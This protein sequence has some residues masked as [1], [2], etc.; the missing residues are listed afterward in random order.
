MYKNCNQHRFFYWPLYIFL[1]LVFSAEIQASSEDTVLLTIADPFIE[2]RTGPG[3]AY[4][5]FHVLDRGQ[6]FSIIERKTLWYKIRSQNKKTGNK[7]GWVSKQ[8]MQQTLLPSGQYLQLSEETQEDFI[9]RQWE[10]G[11]TSGQLA[12]AP[13]LSVYGGYLLTENISAEITLAHS[14]ASVSSSNMVKL[15]LLMQPFPEWW[16]SPFFTLGAGSLQ[17]IPK[18]TLIDPADKQN[19]ISQVGLGIKTYLT[20]KFILRFE[21]NQYIIFSA[22]NDKDENEDIAEW[23]LGFA[24]FF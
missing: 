5:V 17:V 1:L 15:N 13:V 23:K 3:E 6:Q 11:V 19:A 24:I 20:R 2:M 8:Q 9:Q 12:N 21:Y 16:I 4:P 18:A 10:L 22:N 14:V 7:T